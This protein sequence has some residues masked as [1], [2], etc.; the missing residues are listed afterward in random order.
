[1][2]RFEIPRQTAD[3]A[4]TALGEQADISVLYQYELV[5]KHETNQL[6]GSYT[7]EQAITILLSN[8]GLKGEFGTSGHLIIHADGEQNAMIEQT[9]EWMPKA[10]SGKTTTR[11]PLL[12]RLGTAIAAALFATSGA[13]AIAAPG[14]KNE[15]EI[16]EVIVT[17][18]YRETDLMDTPQSIGTLSSDTIEALGAT[19]MRGLFQNI[20][21]LNMSERELAGGNRYTIR[22]VSSPTG[23]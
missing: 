17:A 14:D 23:P 11:K 1:M 10:S 7:L 15:M 4:L 3:G 21:G 8:S 16:E 2:Y 6:R 9:N 18:T 13:G 19:D 22:G 20:T 12:K 5:A